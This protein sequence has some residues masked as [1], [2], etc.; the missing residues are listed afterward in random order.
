MHCHKF[1]HLAAIVAGGSANPYKILRME[2]SAAEFIQQIDL[3]AGGV[4]MR[5]RTSQQLS[6]VTAVFRGGALSLDLARETTLAQLAEQLGVL[7][8]IYG[9]LLLPVN[10]L[11]AADRLD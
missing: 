1:A 9:G 3:P 8:E 7:G 10:V 6:R 11:V 5:D 2:K 4:G